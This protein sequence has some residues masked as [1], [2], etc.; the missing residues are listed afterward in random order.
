MSDLATRIIAS[1]HGTNGGLF[2]SSADIAGR[3]SINVGATTFMKAM[4]TVEQ[5]SEFI[6]LYISP[7]KETQ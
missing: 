7:L 4:V 6:Q 5:H 3:E 2:S 1:A